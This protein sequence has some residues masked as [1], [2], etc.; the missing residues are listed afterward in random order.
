LTLARLQE[1]TLA[2]AEA[3]ELSSLSDLSARNL[4]DLA[5]VYAVSTTAVRDDHKRADQYGDRAM[6]LLRQAVAKDDG[7]LPQ[8]KN[9]PPHGPQPAGG[10][11]ETVERRGE[12]AQTKQAVTALVL[13]APSAR[14]VSMER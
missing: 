13:P 12:E 1:H 14:R 9:D 4:Y 7:N 11:P 10:L 6:E 5:R 2:T 3:N 8:P